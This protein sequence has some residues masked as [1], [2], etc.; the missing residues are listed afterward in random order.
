MEKGSRADRVAELH[1]QLETAVSELVSGED[2]ARMLDA[3]ACFHRYSANN[4]ML[5]MFQRPDASRVA[6][7]RTWQSVGRQV[8]KGEHGIA[9]L[10]PCKYK[11]RLT[12][13][14]GMETGEE[15]WRLGGFTVE[16][17]FDISQTDGEPIADVRPDLLTGQAPA[18]LWDGLARQVKAAG[19]SL[20]RGDCGGANG[21]T[22]FTVRTVRVRDDVDDAQACKTLA[23][24][25]GH[26][27]LHE[28]SLFSCRGVVEVEAE[29]LA[30]IVSAAC[31]L[32]TEGYS[33]PYVA[34][35]AGG[36]VKKVQDSATRVMTVARTILADLEAT[37][38]TRR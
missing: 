7:Y 5:I 26:V 4:V 14:D 28:G 11:V 25:L 31:G 35:W 27:M 9:I 1:G 19:F 15:G 6:G 13:P 36:D 17:V 32:A 20:E 37:E 16:H 18:G 10:A 22:D 12:D 34:L 33:L 3:A 30:Y 24:E 8:R 2:W 29:S 38:E 23:H 21:R